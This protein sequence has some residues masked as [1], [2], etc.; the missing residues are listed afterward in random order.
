MR[1]L[2]TFALVLL[3]VLGTAGAVTDRVV[4]AR[5]ESQVLGALAEHVA[6]A[7]GADVEIDGFPFLTQVRAGRLAEVR[8]SA[9]EIALDGLALTDVR[10]A[11]RGVSPEAPY[12]AETV[13]INADVPLRTLRSVLAAE[14]PLLERV[15]EVTVVD[16]RLRLSTSVAGLALAVGLEPVVLDGRIGFEVG[17]AVAGDDLAADDHLL[18]PLNAALGAVRLDIPALPEGLSPTRLSVVEDGLRLRLEGTEVALQ[19]Q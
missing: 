17:E 7:P 15:L 16:G 5:A 18:E 2:A 13:E 9:P 1:R 8:G 14:V 19:P 10:V 12:R 11:A 3:L 6:L 4:H